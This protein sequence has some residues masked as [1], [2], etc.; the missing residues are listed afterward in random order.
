MLPGGL[1]ANHS[2]AWF[3]MDCLLA[4]VGGQVLEA[5]GVASRTGEELWGEDEG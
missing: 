5:N 3:S 2:A 4:A 1:I